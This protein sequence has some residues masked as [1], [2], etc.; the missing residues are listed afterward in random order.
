[1]K[2]THKLAMVFLGVLVAV[3]AAAAAVGFTVQPALAQEVNHGDEVSGAAEIIGP[4][5]S[6]TAELQKDPGSVSDPAQII[7]PEISE[8]AQ[9]KAIINP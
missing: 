1:M 2:T 8:V 4:E 9:P 3:A 5:I 7:G 6:T